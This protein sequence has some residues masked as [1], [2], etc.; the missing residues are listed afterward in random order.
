MIVSGLVFGEALIGGVMLPA[1]VFLGADTVPVRVQLEADAVVEPGEQVE[2]AGQ[3]YSVV[4]VYRNER[5]VEIIIAPVAVS[6]G[7]KRGK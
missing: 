5:R 3:R 6:Q 7:A 4:S 2:L 1:S